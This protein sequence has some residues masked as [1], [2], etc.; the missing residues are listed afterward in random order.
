MG[1]GMFRSNILERVL[2]RKPDNTNGAGLQR[3][4]KR[5]FLNFLKPLID[6]KKDSSEKDQ[7]I[8]FTA[9]QI[10]S[11]SSM[12]PLNTSIFGTNI[13]ISKASIVGDT[14]SRL[15]EDTTSKKTLSNNGRE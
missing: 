13:A 12:R 8:R 11:L 15:K 6:I 7:G 2:L 4:K 14:T 1:D 5:E 3:K 9:K 10:Q